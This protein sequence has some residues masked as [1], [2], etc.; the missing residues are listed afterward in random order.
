MS[1]HALINFVRPA[2]DNPTLGLHKQANSTPTTDKDPMIS[3]GNQLVQVIHTWACWRVAKRLVD[4]LHLPENLPVHDH[5]NIRICLNAALAPFHTETDQNIA[6]K[7]TDA[8]NTHTNTIISALKA[9]QTLFMAMAA[10]I[11]PKLHA[12]ATVKWWAQRVV[13]MVVANLV[14]NFELLPD[15][16]ASF[17][18]HKGDRGDNQI[19]GVTI[20]AEEHS[21][22]GDQ[23]FWIHK[24]DGGYGNDLDMDTAAWQ[25]F[26]LFDTAVD[27]GHVSTQDIW[28]LYAL[29]TGYLEIS[30]HDRHLANINEIWG[31][32]D[33]G[34]AARACGH[35]CAMA[36]AS[37]MTTQEV[38]AE[39]L[40][41]CIASAIMHLREPVKAAVRT[42][43]PILYS[44]GYS[45]ELT[46]PSIIPPTVDSTALARLAAILR[47]SQR[48]ISADTTFMAMTLPPSSVGSSATAMVAAKASTPTHSTGPHSTETSL[49]ATTKQKLSPTTALGLLLQ[50][51]AATSVHQIGVKPSPSAKVW[52]PKGSPPIA[53]A[54]KATVY[55]TS[56]AKQVIVPKTSVAVA[57]PTRISPQK[58]PK[59]DTPTAV[60]VTHL[61]MDWVP[62]DST[63]R[64]F[65]QSVLVSALKAAKVPSPN[66]I[67]K[68]AEITP[69]SNNQPWVN[70]VF[71]VPYI[72]VSKV[73]GAASDFVMAIRA[74]LLIPA[75]H[76]AKKTQR[77]YK[78]DVEAV[79][80]V[81]FASNNHA[82]TPS[83]GERR[84]STVRSDREDPVVKPVSRQLS[85]T[86]SSKHTDKEDAELGL[87]ADWLTPPPSPS[88]S[89]EPDADCLIHEEFPT[90]S[91]TA[92]AGY[93]K[94][95]TQMWHDSP[96]YAYPDTAAS[97]APSHGLLAG[98]STGPSHGLIE[99]GAGARHRGRMEMETGLTDLMQVPIP[100][101]SRI[102]SP[103]PQQSGSAAKPTPPGPEHRPT[104]RSKSIGDLMSQSRSL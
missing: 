14:N 50:Q 20:M 97:H 74:A 6:A 36:I 79:D 21:T 18:L 38:T 86:F 31:Q 67:A 101:R 91:G 96:A 25:Q 4:D 11:N 13:R 39:T 44:H 47:T 27:N 17:Q 69:S 61:R 2:L 49:A 103:G 41:T 22:K 1:K 42:A 54:T 71:N 81:T 29:A 30:K 104:T 60:S 9:R 84:T 5:E 26:Q 45:E 35:A 100:K 16:S 98:H 90:H 23:S 78:E 87:E 94:A 102:H 37:S 51:H 55:T 59:K 73:M 62:A 70:I 57:A 88:G 72:H 28:G 19:V 99:G 10:A 52:P 95:T 77:L 80:T 64:P 32:V 89:S 48:Q 85:I 8:I 92:G 40:Q 7:M 76:S 68:T 46:E 56:T 66:P 24:G 15:V 93:T 58:L 12:R 53:S 43:R 33:S 65:F 75:R 34:L 83:M 82:A 3:A 63:L